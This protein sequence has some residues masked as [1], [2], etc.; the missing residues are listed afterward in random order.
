MS[1]SSSSAIS[2]NISAWQLL[3]LQ[4]HPS[5]RPLSSDLTLAI[6]A[7]CDLICRRNFSITCLRLPSRP[8]INGLPKIVVRST[9]TSQG[10]RL[11]LTTVV[12]NGRSAF[13]PSNSC[14]HLGHRR[15]IL[16]VRSKWRWNS[17]GDIAGVSAIIMLSWT[18]H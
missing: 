12:G 14:F 4:W 5:T 13:P 10:S 15:T 2:A 6:S 18:C 1:E 11:Q 8:I 9:K 16:E 7:G 3:G 17:L